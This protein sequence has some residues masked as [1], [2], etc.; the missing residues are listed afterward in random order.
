MKTVLI[1]IILLLSV[2]GFGQHNDS[3][4]SF[5]V[6]TASNRPTMYNDSTGIIIEGDTMKVIRDLFD[7]CIE[8]EIKYNKCQK[9]YYDLL[10]THI[11]LFE[12]AQG[13]I[14]TMRN[15][16]TEMHD[17]ITPKKQINEKAYRIGDSTMPY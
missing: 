5:M 17:I 4:Y 16:L 6:F 9:E 13:T 7:Q 11:K 3:S 15:G 1:S 10:S 12:I 8:W 2:M 14:S